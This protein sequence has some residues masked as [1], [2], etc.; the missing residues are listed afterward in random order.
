[1]GITLS[2]T[3][4]LFLGTSCKNKEN[5]I[6]QTPPVFSATPVDMAYDPAD[7]SCGDIMFIAP[8]VTPFGA[9]LPPDYAQTSH[10]IE[11]FT[12]PGAPVRAVTHGTVDTIIENPV[13]QG[14]LQIW[15]VSLP[16]AD[17]TVIY[18]HVVNKM[19]LDGSFVGPDT[20][21]GQAGIWNDS[22]G[23]V[24]LAVTVGEGADQ[25]WYCPL[26]FGDS[27]FVE[28]HRRLLEE[29]TRRGFAP[30]YDSLCLQGVLGP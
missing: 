27:A 2:V 14:D 19:V 20:I 30:E 8:V 16:G 12:V 4:L 6:T 17:Y 26:R 21:L 28:D 24:A 29:Y 3:L 13:E 1:M 9:A 5:P 25:K 23:W 7:S 18:D 22:M 10:F 15:V 11:Y